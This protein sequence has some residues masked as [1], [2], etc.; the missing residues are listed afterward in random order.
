[1]SRIKTAHP[2]RPTA[3]HRMARHPA[4][5]HRQ[6]IRTV[7]LPQNPMNRAEIRQTE[8]PNLQAAANVPRWEDGGNEVSFTESGE[9]LTV[10]VKDVEITENGQTVSADELEEGDILTIAYGDKNSIESIEVYTA[11]AGG[12]QGGGFGGST[13]VT[14]GESANTITLAD[15]TV[16][17]Q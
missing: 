6:A 3:K 9:T 4:D 16:L 5:R 13:T 11:A 14:Q 12:P 1:M 8:T 2:P 15:G 17:G 7:P 10:D